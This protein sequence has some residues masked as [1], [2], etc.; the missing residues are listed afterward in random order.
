MASYRANSPYIDD[1]LLVAHRACANSA[2]DNLHNVLSA[3]NIKLSSTEGHVCPPTH[4]MRALGFDINLDEGTISLPQHKLQEMLEFAAYV[5]EADQITRQDIKK[6]VGR[7]SRCIMVIREGRRFLSRLLLLLQGPPLPANTVVPIPDGAKKDLR[8]WLTYGPRLNSKTLL[9]LQ[10]LPLTSVF[11]VDGRV[12]TGSPPTVGGLCYH[13]SEFFSMEVPSCFHHQP[14]HIIE[15]IAL[16]AASRL[17]VPKMPDG[18]IIPIGSDNQ[19]VVLSYQHGRAKEP[20]LAAMARL[21]WG[22][23]A[24]STCSFYLRYVPSH[25][26]SSDGVSRLNPQHI[27]FLRSQKWKQLILPKEYFAIDEDFPFSYQEVIPKSCE[28]K[29]ASSAVVKCEINPEDSVKLLEKF[30][31]FLSNI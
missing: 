14:I 27:N 25:E 15:A 26:N 5:L 23:F 8:W 31:V 19:A 21:L 18:F 10:T 22:V 12:G 4:C 3:A 17:W 30:L 29:S 20:S 1:S 6:L 9:T 11:L 28:R 16:L 13:T 7:I 24:T 2:W